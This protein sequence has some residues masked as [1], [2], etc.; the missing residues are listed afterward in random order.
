M[1]NTPLIESL[2]S[3]RLLSVSVA[4]HPMAHAK[5][6][7]PAAEASAESEPADAT[8][9]TDASETSNTAETD[10][11]Q[12]DQ[13]ST[14]A[15]GPD[16]E[17]VDGGPGGADSTTTAATASAAKLTAAALR[18]GTAVHPTSAAVH[19]H[20]SISGTYSTSTPV[21]DAGTTYN[22]TG[23]GVVKPLGTTT[24]SGN[25]AL[26]GFVA[27]GFAT[28]TL[29]LTG[30]NGTVTLSLKGPRQK[31]FGPLPSNLSFTIS[32]GTGS[33]AGAKGSGHIALKLN[34]SATSFV[35]KFG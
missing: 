10:T 23:S 1:G 29:T 31:G 12:G 7:A 32:S 20:G 13:N 5:A 2:E 24:V 22:F 18:R 15:D 25:I 3:R 8:D 33:Y 30:P 4:V 6:M 35:L 16:G 14:A 21:A 9:T 28:G 11:A 34:T 26:P 27:S 19:P 17:N